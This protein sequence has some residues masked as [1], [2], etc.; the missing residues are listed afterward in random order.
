[1]LGVFAELECSIIQQRVRTGLQRAKR[2]GSRAS[3]LSESGRLW[4]G[5]MNLRGT[6]AKFDVKGTKPRER[7]FYRHHFRGRKGSAC[8]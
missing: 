5:V 3:W 1:M 7:N 6:A 4:R 8:R 2:E